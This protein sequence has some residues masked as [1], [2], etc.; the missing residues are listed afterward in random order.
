MKQRLRFEFTDLFFKQGLGLTIDQLV[1]AIVNVADLRF[2]FF[3][4]GRQV[5]QV[6]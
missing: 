1:V 5:Q 2:P 3:K 6:G 4:C